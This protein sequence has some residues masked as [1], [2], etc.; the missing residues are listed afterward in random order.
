MT[1]SATSAASPRYTNLV[2]TLHWVM[3]LLIVAA[4]VTI[5]AREFYPRGSVTRESLKSLHYMIGLT[6]LALLA[7]R[8]YARFSSGV[9][10]I[11]PEPVAWQKL[12]A[13]GV[14][15]ALLA[16]M[17]VLPVT[18]WIILS[19]EGD[20]IPF[21]GLEL[22]ALVGPDQTLADSLEELHESVG[23]IGYYLIG[24]HSA[25]ALFHHYFVKD[26]TL[27]RMLPGRRS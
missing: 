20:P 2:I 22:P 14:H 19:A 8:V 5:E 9:P 24:L 27:V 13:R 12:A 3:A 17:L 6:V 25:A 15:L 4:Y 7:V 18:G 16:L 23:E 11:T 26:N 10:A 1:S 21:W